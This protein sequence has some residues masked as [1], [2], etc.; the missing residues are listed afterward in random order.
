PTPTP[1]PTPS[2]GVTTIQFAASPYSAVE[3]DQIALI[4]VTRTGD[5]TGTSSV[6]FATIDDPAAIRCDDTVN[7]HGAAF[8]RCDYSSTAVTLMFA[9][10]ERQKTAAVSLTDDAFVEGPESLHM[11]LSEVQG[12]TLGTPT[13]ATLFII[14]ND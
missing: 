10:G 7:N 14:D 6:H 1:T 2:P 3:D 12:A 5:L 8:A 13:D 9:P 11:Q 4:R